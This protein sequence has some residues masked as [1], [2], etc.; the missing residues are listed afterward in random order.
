MKALSVQ[1]ESRWLVF[2]FVFVFFP[3]ERH[4]HVKLVSASVNVRGVLNTYGVPI[5]GKALCWTV[6]PKHF[7]YF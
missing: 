6:P 4:F 7:F 5:K 1:L 2:V 3:W